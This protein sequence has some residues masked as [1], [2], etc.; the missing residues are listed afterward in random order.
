MKNTISKG[1]HRIGILLAILVFIFGLLS[2]ET[3]GFS[4]FDILVSLICALLVYSVT[5]LAGWAI[6]GFMKDN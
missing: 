1:F 4:L 6:K 2:T 5:R 3:R